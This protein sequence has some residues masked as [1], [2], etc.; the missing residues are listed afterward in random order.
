VGK[1]VVIRGERGSILHVLELGE[2]VRGE[3]TASVEDSREYVAVKY[4]TEDG[5]PKGIAY[6]YDSDGFKLQPTDYV[7]VPGGGTLLA[8]VVVAIGLPDPPTSLHVKKVLAPL[9]E[10]DEWL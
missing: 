4:L 9:D 6:T 1:R 3:V 2:Q 5:Q 8:G 7:V 10:L